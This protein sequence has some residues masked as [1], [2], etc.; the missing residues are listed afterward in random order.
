MTGKL[1]LTFI[2]MGIGVM[3]IAVDIAA[4]NVAL[5]SVEKDFQTTIGTVEWVVNGYVLAWAVLMVTCGRLADMFGRRKIFFIGLVVFGAASLIGALAHDSGVLIAA[6]V[7]Q[8]AGAALLWPAILGIVYSSVSDAQKGLA[9]GLILGAAGIG[10]AAGPLLGG[11][12]TELYSWRAVLYF[13]I[14]F[15]FVAGLITYFV[16]D[17]RRSQETRG[18]IDYIGILTVSLSLVSLL[19]A[20][21]QSTSWGWTSGK[22]LGL[23]VLFAVFLVVFIV[24]ERKTPGALIPEDVM[25]N[26]KFMVTGAMMPLAVPAFFSILLFVPQYLE[27]FHG[28]SPVD[29]GAG[30]VPMLLSFA[31]TAPVSGTIYNRLG[32]RWSIFT[33]MVLLSVGT[34]LILLFGFGNSYS[35]MVPGL[36]IFGIG[37]GFSIPSITTAAVGA[38]NEA[39]AS[40][41]GGIIYMFELAGGALGLAVITTIFTDAVRKDISVKLSELGFGLT[42]PQKADLLD[43][44]LGSGSRE[45]LV[46]ELGPDKVNTVFLHVRESF[47]SGLQEG[48]GF[49]TVVL[50]VGAVLTL[51]FIEGKKS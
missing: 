29:S 44:I 7:V 19:Y 10:N 9:V 4:I 17:E 41:A 27:K 2:A 18:R 36:I 48:L 12:L 25:N 31:L 43:F 6:R 33:G 50:V 8:G 51:I 11:F 42:G 16:V 38:V 47:V 40:L 1:I 22:T 14:P 45:A 23:L 49:A 28:Y 24:H 3:V 34:V 26:R 39:R 32:P 37:V 21:N 46:N 20:V 13:N 5:P 30:L 15:A 35:G